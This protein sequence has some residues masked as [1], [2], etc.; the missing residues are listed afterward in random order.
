LLLQAALIVLPVTILSVVAF[1]SIRQDKAAVL[2]DARDRA[3]PAAK[4]LAVKV[5]LRVEQLFKSEKLLEGFIAGGRVQTP[6]DAGWLLT[7]PDWPSHLSAK[8]DSLWQRAQSA[9]FQRNDSG[10]SRNALNALKNSTESTPARANAALLLLDLDHPMDAVAYV[11]LARRYPDIATDSGAPLATIALLHALRAAPKGPLPAGFLSELDR[12]VHASPSFLTGQVMDMAARVP[13]R[14]ERDEVRRLQQEWSN[15]RTTVEVLHAILKSP[16]RPGAPFQWWDTGKTALALGQPFEGGWKVSIVP[17][18]ILVAILSRALNENAVPLRGS[19]A[20]IYIG[21]EQLLTA[22]FHPR[23][24]TFAAA[25]DAHISAPGFCPF[26]LVILADDE[27]LFAAQ[28]ARLWQ[29]SALI[30]CAAL[31]AMIG[32]AALW[33]GYQRQARLS[34][35]KS[36]FVSSVSH[37][38]RAPLGAVRLMA[39][40]LERDKVADPGQRQEYYRLIGQECRRLSSLVENVLDFSRM[41]AGCKQYTFEPVDLVALVQH[42]VAVMQPS[43]ADRGVALQFIPA[44]EPLQ[45]SWDAAAIEQALVNLVDNA[46]KHSPFGATVTLEIESGGDDLRVWVKDAGPGIPVEEQSRIF[47]LF[48]RRGSELR[49]ETTGAGIGLTIVKH[50]AEA[51]GGRVIVASEMGRGSR[52]ALELPMR[53]VHA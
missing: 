44:A 18:Q 47:D 28:R 38:L 21:G 6:S 4:D 39:E 51:H 43:A 45:P 23:S 40:N 11:D 25:A 46:I 19:K 3:L 20:Q 10:A 37:E 1:Y 34:E 27:S 30:F 16:A 36:N 53:S 13:N 2:R 15:W 8:D 41:E 22:T 14:A 33:R 52:F 9:L 7:T 31:A 35:M 49:R 12:E 48:Y 42:A 29:M 17:R 5:G 26:H 32:L 24:Y 50:V